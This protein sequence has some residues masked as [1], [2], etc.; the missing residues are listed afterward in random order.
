MKNVL[1]VCDLDGTLLNAAGE[2]DQES[3]KKIQ[4]FC[5]DGGHFTICTGR[6]DSDIRYV[7]EAL[8]FK[9]EYRISQ[10]GAV[11]KNKNDQLL[12]VETIPEE[13]IADL[14][15]TIFNAGL[16]TEV[17]NISNRH[18]PSPR[19][20]ENVAEFVD[21]SIIVPE[22]ADFVLSSNME[23][24]IYLTFG[25]SKE[26]AKIKQA[27]ELKL[28]VD[29]VNIVQTSPSSLEVFSKKVSK[30][31]AVQLIQE[32]LGILSKNIYVVGDAESDLSMFSLTD[33]AYAVQD[34]SPDI[35]QKADFYCKTVGDV[36]DVIYKDQEKNK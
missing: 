1:L 3:L 13:Y 7:E 23:P 5:M 14:T 11:V 8:G 33:K 26:F 20:P 17:S 30:G 2:I 25:T 4:K 29:S 16:R 21:S 12:S 10:N 24:T 18:Y 32:R 31:I 34:A 9:S 6:M 15:Q 28:G 35:R 19:N 22:L 36:V 27:I